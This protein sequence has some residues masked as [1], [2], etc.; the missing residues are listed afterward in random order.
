MILSN[1]PKHGDGHREGGIDTFFAGGSLSES[2]KQGLGGW[3]AWSVQT[4][5]PKV[6]RSGSWYL[7][8]VSARH[9]A[10]EAGPVD[11]GQGAQFAGGQDGLEVR[12]GASLRSPGAWV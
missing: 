4:A 12:M 10:D 6:G 3:V 11:V 7:D 8:H 5:W 2:R 1:G 9:H